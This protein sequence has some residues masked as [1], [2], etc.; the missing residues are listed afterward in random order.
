MAEHVAFPM[1]G[2]RTLLCSIPQELYGELAAGWLPSL[3]T[4]GRILDQLTFLSTSAAVS[5]ELV[6]NEGIIIP[7]HGRKGTKLNV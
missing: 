6:I 1:E 7:L 3:S 5:N 2:M 4:A